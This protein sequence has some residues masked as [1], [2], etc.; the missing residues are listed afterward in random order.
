ML[1]PVTMSNS[2]RVPLRVQP[3]R[4]PAPKA[5]LLPPPEIARKNQSGVPVR[6]RDSTAALV[7]AAR[8]MLSASSPQKRMPA[9]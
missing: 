9:P 6:T 7:I 4:I 5:P 2:G 8:P 1:T 3:L